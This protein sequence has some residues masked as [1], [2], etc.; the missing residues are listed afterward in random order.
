MY[1]LITV[2]DLNKQIFKNKLN[3]QNYQKQHKNYTYN[4]FFYFHIFAKINN[5]FIPQT[6]NK[7]SI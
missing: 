5:I 3:N 6:N 1:N 4:L 7:V 2:L